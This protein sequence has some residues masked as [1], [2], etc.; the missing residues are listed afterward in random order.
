MSQER[1]KDPIFKFLQNT[2]FKS[3]SND[4]EMAIQQWWDTFESNE[5]K[6]N[7]YFIG[8]GHSDF[9]LPL[10][11]Q[12]NLQVINSDIMWEFGPGLK[13][14]HRLVITS[15]SRRELRPLV[16]YILSKAPNMEFFEFY[17]YRLPESLEAA[18]AM[19]SS[20]TNWQDISE[21]G[22]NTIIGDYNRIDITFYTPFS[23]SDDEQTNNLYLITEQLL[24]EEYQ[25]NWMGYID[26]LPKPKKKSFLGFN[27]TGAVSHLPVGQ[28]KSNFE[29]NI[30][31]VKGALPE[32]HYHEFSE[33]H[34]WSLLKLRPEKKEDYA[35]K[36]DMFVAPSISPQL[37]DAL[38]RG[39]G[40]FYSG[41][42]SNFGE[43]F[44][45]LKMDG[46]AD[47]LNQEIFP[48][49]SSIEDALGEALQGKGSIIGG[50]TGLRYSY[51]DFAL[52]DLE[53]SIDI[54]QKI[55]Q[56]GKI[57]KRSWLFFHDPIYQLE[58]IGIWPDSPE[59][60]L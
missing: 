1:R 14:A 43:T 7:S 57:T 15:E 45:F 26:V 20:R 22:F 19:V 36:D 28:L 18:N 54:I 50:G 13:K 49:R 53:Q 52:T 44:M 48:D 11:V 59:P 16:R 21:I 10:W 8:D 31:V 2:S 27:K 46:S 58:W 29:E 32:K 38:H 40:N 24:G 41:R 30:A 47:D 51:I 60:Y 56:D 37:F 9:D 34:E 23:E 42:F 12:Q 5:G 35:H 17:E 33:N 3:I 6:I 55:L 25:D 39:K 4:R